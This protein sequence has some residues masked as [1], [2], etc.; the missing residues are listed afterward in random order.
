MILVLYIGQ[1]Y[2]AQATEA[3]ENGRAYTAY[4]EDRVAETAL[5]ASA[6][7]AAVKVAQDN[8]TN[9]RAAYEIAFN[10]AKVTPATIAAVVAAQSALAKATAAAAAATAAAKAALAVFAGAVIGTYIGQGVRGIWDWCWDPV[11]D[12]TS[13]FIQQPVQIHILGPVPN[14]L[15]IGE[16]GQITASVEAEPIYMPATDDEIDALIPELVE[17]ATDSNLTLTKEDF[18]AAGDIGLISKDF[19]TQGAH[20]F[21]GAARGAATATAGRSVEVLTAVTDLQAE[22][23]EYRTTI[24]IFADILEVTAF[25]SPVSEFQ[26]ARTEFDAAVAEVRAVCNTSEGDD[27]AT[28]NDALDEA[29]VAFQ[30]AQDAVST[31]DF[32]ALVGGSNPLLE[33]LLLEKFLSFLEKTATSGAA[34]LPEGEILLADRLLQEA[35]VFF[36]GMTS[37]G[38][39]IAAYDAKGDTGGRESA[40]FDPFTEEINLAELLRGSATI[41]SPSGFWLDIDLETSPVTQEASLPGQGDHEVVFT[42]LLGNLTFTQGVVSPDG[43][44]ATVFTQS[45]GVANMSFITSGAG[46]ALVKVAVT[47]T[48]L[49]TFSF[50]FI[51]P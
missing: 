29:T 46:P 18:V 40:L 47:G 1:I 23:A 21:I 5:L 51:K 27:C 8:L 44:R 43:T 50:F 6:A 38:P 19:I 20:K 4:L 37:F 11:C 17:I 39:A 45:G 25:E 2:P 14:Q 34:A 32:P 42:K 41:L 33:N 48:E 15:A 7:A 36:P 24:E 13:F 10:A 9:A 31:V 26:T 30:D 22:L 3:W 16:E 12:A 35:K 49:S 28:I